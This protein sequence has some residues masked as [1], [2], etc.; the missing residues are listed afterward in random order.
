MEPV[1][2]PR[3]ALLPNYLDLTSGGCP[4]M[5]PHC[6]QPLFPGSAPAVVNVTVLNLGGVKGAITSISWAPGPGGE[7]L[8]VAA[9]LPDRFWPWAAGLGVHIRVA[10][11]G[12]ASAAAAAALADLADTPTVASGVLRLTVT[13]VI[14]GT[15]SRVE[16]PIR[17]DVVAAPPR[18]R[19]LL[20]DTYHSLRYPPAYVPRDSLAETKDMLDWL[21]DHPHTNFHALYR[22]LRGAGYFVDVWT[23]PATC[24]PADV[25]ARYGALLVIDAEDYFATAEVAAIT[26]AVHDG[27]LALIVV[28]E[29]YSRPL[30]RDVRFEDDNTRS[31][32][33]PVIGG[34]NVPALNELLRPHG[35]AL[36]DTV[37]SG[38]VAGAAPYPRYGFMSGAP[39]VRVD[40]GGEALRAR[41]LRPHLPRR[42]PG[43][44][45]APPV[46]S[47]A[48]PPLGA[49]VDAVVLAISRAVRGAVAVFGDSNCVDT[50][51]AGGNCHALFTAVVGHAVAA[52][53]SRAAAYVPLLSGPDVLTGAAP[54][55]G[56]AAGDVAS[57]PPPSG[58][59][60][61][62]PHSRVLAPPGA[63]GRFRDLSAACYVPPS[64]PAAAAAVAPPP[65]RPGAPKA[66]KATPPPTPLPAARAS[67][68][69]S[70]R[71]ARRSPPTRSP[72]ST[73]RRR[74]WA[75]RPPA[76]G[77]CSPTR[78]ACRSRSR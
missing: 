4:Y 78:R 36:G 66:P 38:E 68:T 48:A 5:W 55:L 17:A 49:P 32:W 40:L 19:R 8:A 39:I 70:R 2:A 58:V 45:A 52:A 46:A 11:G 74:C 30:M 26:A 64:P 33:T 77:G 21:G 25:A 28:A 56:V 50:A 43:G 75:S 73:T 60:L 47:A 12:G 41:G 20:W 23:Q 42:G 71:C 34:G 13:S 63:A 35:L 44:G 16:L 76:C 6:A 37:L 7:L 61:L 14:E 10:D 29:W 69:A 9:S 1:A 27:G 15:V 31:W 22:H 3:A 59:A 54:L 72:A 62:R 65:P 53:G 57:P 24:L 51:Y 67:P 18:E